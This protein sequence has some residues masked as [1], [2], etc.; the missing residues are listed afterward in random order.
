MLAY[1][2]S[3]LL[4][5]RFHHFTDSLVT[6]YY[7][8][9]F[10]TNTSA[11]IYLASQPFSLYGLLSHSHERGVRSDSSYAWL[12][13]LTLSVLPLTLFERSYVVSAASPYAVEQRSY[14][15]SVVCV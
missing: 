11:G 2:F 9:V 6:T 3:V 15:R 14:A 10:G 12:A 4:N 5:L 7:M 1:L 8:H 13:D